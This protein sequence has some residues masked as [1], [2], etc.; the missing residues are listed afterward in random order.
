MHVAQIHSSSTTGMWLSYG[1]E[2]IDCRA[3]QGPKP[4]KGNEKELSRGGTVSKTLEVRER[5]VPDS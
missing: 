3:K 4:N 2:C 5:V 1:D